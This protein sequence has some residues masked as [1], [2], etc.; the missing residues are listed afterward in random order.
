[1]M[2]CT[3]AGAVWTIIDST[4]DTYNASIYKLAPNSTGEENNITDFGSPTTVNQIDILSNGFK[5]RGTDGN[6][7]ANG[8]TYIYM[9]FAANPFKNSNAF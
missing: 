6:Q 9:A 2:K 4:R 1:M 5:Q 7:N 3:T 8:Q